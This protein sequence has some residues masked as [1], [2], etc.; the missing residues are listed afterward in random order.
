MSDSYI[1]EKDLKEYDGE[2]SD[3]WLALTPPQKL[4]A[5]EMAGELIGSCTFFVDDQGQ[6]VAPLVT[7]ETKNIVARIAESILMSEQSIKHKENTDG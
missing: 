5:I 2:I 3:A 6:V 7:D 4:L 1:S